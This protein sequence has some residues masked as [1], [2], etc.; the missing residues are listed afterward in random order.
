M[1]EKVKS[2]TLG[3]LNLKR[4][5]LRIL[6]FYN[7]AV[8]LT[9]DINTLGTAIEIYQRKC[10]DGQLPT[11]L[12]EDVPKDPFTGR[13]FAYEITEDGFELLLPDDNIPEQRHRAY[14]FKVQK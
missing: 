1:L 9:A 13:D 7:L 12:P 6:K 2:V 3:G 4:L 5:Q 8:E 11:V 10:K 14:E